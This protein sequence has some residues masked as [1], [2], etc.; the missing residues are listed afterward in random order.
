VIKFVSDL[1]QVGGFLVFSTNKTDHRA[2][3]SGTV[4]KRHPISKTA[5][6]SPK[7]RGRPKTDVSVIKSEDTEQKVQ[8]IIKRIKEDLERKSDGK[9][10]LLK[11][12]LFNRTISVMKSFM[13]SY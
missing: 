2:N 3:S 4:S 6:E 10:K 9:R 5:E 12:R 11:L 13:Y 8:N 7:K 1:Q